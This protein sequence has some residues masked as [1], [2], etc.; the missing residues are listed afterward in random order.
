MILTA[1]Q[2]KKYDDFYESTHHNQFLDAKTELLVGLAAALAAGCIPCMKY[3]LF[4]AKE[5][6]I[7][8]GEISEV[9]AKVMAVTAGQKRLQ[10]EEVM[11]KYQIDLDG[12]A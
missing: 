1:E 11:Q 9:I 7:K 6:G 4:K 5:A 8:R 12:Y 2:Q 3:Y 10:A